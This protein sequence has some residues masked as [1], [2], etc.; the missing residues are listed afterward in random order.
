MAYKHSLIGSL[1]TMVCAVVGFISFPQLANAAESASFRLY[2]QYPND[3]EGGPSESANFQFGIGRMTVW[4]FPLVSSSFQLVST[5]APSGG[6]SS[7]GG[8]GSSS[9]GGTDGGG[10]DG[11][12]G[13][14]PR[15]IPS[16]EEPPA[17]P[18][19]KPRRPAAPAKPKP[20]KA[21]EVQVSPFPQEE[22]GF[23][24]A[25]SGAE[26]AAEYMGERLIDRIHF[27]HLIDASEQ[28]ASARVARP[29]IEQWRFT[30]LHLL[31]PALHPAVVAIFIL[32]FVSMGLGL[33]VRNAQAIQIHRR[34][35]LFLFFL[36]FHGG[37]K[38]ESFVIRDLYQQCRAGK[39]SRLSLHS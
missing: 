2:Q 25:P 11:S 34:K 12:G 14:R 39:R 37:K 21:P 22:A 8:G 26:E 36:L 24:T 32:L 16:P 1:L 18:Q 23:P 29:I 4:Q 28:E 35:Y 9:G 27:F 15:P 5:L 33:V 38:E 17:I 19:E 20:G 10:G 6:G 31:P 30:V 7:S 13:R 3:A